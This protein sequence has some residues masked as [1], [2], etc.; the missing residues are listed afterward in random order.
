MPLSAVSTEKPWGVR[1]EAFLRRV[2]L[3]C[4]CVRLVRICAKSVAI[5]SVR[6]NGS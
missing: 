4:I 5:V 1:Q 3:G 2:L 6:I